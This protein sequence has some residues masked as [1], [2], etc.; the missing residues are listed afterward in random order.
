MKKVRV[1][2]RSGEP[3]FTVEFENNL[4]T[5]LETGISVDKTKEE[6]DAFISNLTE[7][8]VA[9]IEIL[10]EYE[11]RVVFQ[12]TVQRYF[13]DNGE[14]RAIPMDPMKD[15]FLHDDR[16][17]AFDK[18]YELFRK[19]KSDGGSAGEH[20]SVRPEDAIHVI[21]HIDG[22]KTEIRTIAKVIK[23]KNDITL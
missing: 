13:P 12:T 16:A 8:K 11:T 3:G 5:C 7:M 21:R 10:D 18:H 22:T 19:A 20:E 1:N 2:Y 15:I 9:D 14:D 23:I 17:E 6:F 4:M